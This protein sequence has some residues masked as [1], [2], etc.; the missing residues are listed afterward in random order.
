M[1]DVVIGYGI[2]RWTINIPGRDSTIFNNGRY[3]NVKAERDGKWV[4]VLLHSSIPY[5]L[6]KQ[7]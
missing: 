6:P 7:K 4:Y 5:S 2:W 1:G 3:S